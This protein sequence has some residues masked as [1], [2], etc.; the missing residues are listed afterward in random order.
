M[1]GEGPR[2]PEGLLRVDPRDAALFLGFDGALVERAARPGEVRVPARLD[3]LLTFLDRASNGGTVVLTG[4]SRAALK[5]LLPVACGVIA[6]HGAERHLFGG[7]AFVHPLAGSAILMELQDDLE[8][9]A[10]ARPGLAVE[11]TAAGATVSFRRCPE[12]LDDLRRLCRSVASAVPALEMRET[13]DA[14]A[15]GPAGA[16]LARAVDLALRHRALAGRFPVMFG[17]DEADEPALDLVRR[18]GGLSV[19]VGSGPSVAEYRLEGPAEV[20]GLLAGWLERAM[21]LA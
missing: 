6:S 4:R 21:G 8:R 3:T 5:R 2:P 16:G 17:A 1:T 14:I 20:R 10:A 11:R 12:M 19:K 13:E 9:L 15:L 18:R 7:E